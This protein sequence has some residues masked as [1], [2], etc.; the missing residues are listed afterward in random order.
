MQKIFIAEDDENIR[1]LIGYA[2]KNSGFETVLFPNGK[3]VVLEAEKISPDLILLDIMMPEVD[4]MTVLMNLREN[5]KTKTI[6]VIML[7]AKSLEMDKVRGLDTGADDY[8][9]KPFSVVELISRVKA[10]L[11]RAP[12]IKDE[13]VLRLGALEVDG[14]KR[15]ATVSGKEAELTFK[16]FELL[17]LLMKNREKVLSRDQ[18]IN[19]VWDYDFVGE[20][21]TVDMHVK[22]LRHKLGACGRYIVTVR[23][24]GYVLR[25]D[26]KEGSGAKENI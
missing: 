2:L 18:I 21:R 8:M 26:S 12:A 14:V 25:P 22:A 17:L 20:S 19:A 24:V 13:G 4:G 23:N 3:N 16:E 6:P 9:T 1:E 10:V 5:L 11:R 15:T 7:T